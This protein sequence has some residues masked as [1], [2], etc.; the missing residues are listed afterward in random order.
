M[1][2]TWDPENGEE[3]QTWDFDPDDV[4]GEDAKKIERHYGGSWD[5]WIAGLQT[6]Q[7]QARMVLLW[8]M[9]KQVHDKLKFEDLPKFRVRQLK[10]EMGV[11]EL[12]TLFTRV[13]RMKLSDEDRENF[14]MAFEADM[15][16]AMKREFPDGAAEVID[17]KLSIEGAEDDLP[18][19][20]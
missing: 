10:V 1:Q 6:G 15:A 16:D 17:G 4:L 11:R 13:Q 12:R 3:K 20:A 8:Y 5:Q 18:K 19:P 7:I 14:E 2:V 9:M